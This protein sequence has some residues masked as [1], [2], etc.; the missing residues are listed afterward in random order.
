MRW[1]IAALIFVLPWTSP[2]PIKPQTMQYWATGGSVEA[3][4]VAP[5]GKSGEIHVEAPRACLSME[6]RVENIAGE[7]IHVQQTLRDGCYRVYV[8]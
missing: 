6:V 2:E 8:P 3:S 1:F 4:I 7:I 5:D